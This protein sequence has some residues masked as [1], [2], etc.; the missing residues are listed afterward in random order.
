V[1]AFLAT[2]LIYALLAG[3]RT[4]YDVDLGWQLATGRWIVQHHRVPSV[5]V[6]SYTAQG[7][8]WIYPALSGV[9]L[10]WIYV[11][12]GYAGLSWL[13]AIASA[14]AT[15]FL[16]R[17]RNL[18][19]AI[20]AIVAVP[21][22]VLRL[23]PRADLFSTVLFA[24][25]L[26]ILWRYYRSG[27]GRLWLLPIILMLWVNLHWGFVTGL[28]L[29]GAYV[30][31]EVG[32]M[33]FA[34]RREAAKERLKKAWPWLG[35]SALATLVNPWGVKLYLEMFDWTK[36]LA[37]SQSAVISEF[38]PM[39]FTWSAMEGALAW[40]DPDFSAIWWLL[41]AALAG[42]VAAIVVR[43][44]G[45]VVLLVGSAVAGV[46]RN[47]FQ[48]LFACVVVVVAGSI[49]HQAWET[50]RLKREA[51]APARQN[52]FAQPIAY[53][54]CFVILVLAGMR[55]FDLVSNR[56]YLNKETTEAFGTG[57]SWWFPERAAAFV[58]REHLPGNIFNVWSLGG[59]LAWRL[60]QYPDFIDGRGKPF[61]KKVFSAA[62]A[63][64]SEVSD[65]AAWQ[66]AAD[67]WGLQTIVVATGRYAGLVDF[68]NLK[69]FCDSQ[70]W[71]PVYLDEV[72]AVF[73]RRSAST[74][75]LI[76][77]LELNCETFRFIPPPADTNR[78]ERFNFFSNAAVLMDVLGRPQE[79]LQ[80]LETAEK[81]APW[82]GPVR[83]ERGA[84][85]GKLGNLDEAER[86]LRE[87]VELRPDENSWSGLSSVLLAEQRYE[88]AAE[89][90][91]K[92]AEVS[93][94][95]QRYYV[96]LSRLELQRRQPTQSLAALDEAMKFS[97][98]N[99]ESAMGAEFQAEVAEG[100]AQ[101]WF[102][103]GDMQRAA[104]FEEQA[105]RFTPD[106]AERWNDMANLYQA[107]GRS[108]EAEQA[109]Q[110]AKQSTNS[111]VAPADLPR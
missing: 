1:Y 69:E 60:P 76:D 70:G 97:V 11:L 105:V 93:F 87:S 81:L 6:L 67:E 16:T 15:F 10:Y 94:A 33:L 7:R 9:L 50:Y 48:G 8:P 3:L 39:R 56:Y 57:L 22:V 21:V 107:L 89:V 95:P 27:K 17:E 91:N 35:A 43:N 44:Y 85:L 104:G 78:A 111:P 62:I 47:R 34:W 102:A 84:L 64:P 20:L 2:A 101:A 66:Q 83:Y 79:A 61:T 45:A 14:A 41:A 53:A 5:D 92:A 110:H 88:E 51:T 32:E 90:L 13:T 106:N 55:S 74:Q 68:P 71:S 80:E 100:R 103:L 24:A 98:V 99:D 23:T 38:S 36:D 49:L 19:T 96:Q 30:V 26:S 31:L 40:R 29:C 37:S 59:Y 77:R 12:S 109:M 54:L 63:L 82:S 75:A 28:G 73:V 4:I 18:A 52:G 86:E 65:S 72:S 42:T 108:S 25:V 46:E 58:E